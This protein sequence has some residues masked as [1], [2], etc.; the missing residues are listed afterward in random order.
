MKAASAIDQR[1]KILNYAV[2]REISFRAHIITEPVAFCHPTL[3]RATA[4]R[5]LLYT[6]F[7]VKKNFVK[8]EDLYSVISEF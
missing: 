5:G 7:L 6:R 2:A 4:A 8:A 1:F 3:R